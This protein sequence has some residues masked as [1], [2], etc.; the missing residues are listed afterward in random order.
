MSDSSARPA[1]PAEIARLAHAIWEAEG[2][3]HGRDREHWERAER[4]LE[5]GVTDA[6]APRPEMPGP[7]NPEPIPP[8]GEEGHAAVPSTEAAAAG[9]LHADA[10]PPASGGRR[11]RRKPAE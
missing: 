8:I 10:A 1:T 3:P 4:M 6:G 9:A 5:R 11:A 2:R 7:R